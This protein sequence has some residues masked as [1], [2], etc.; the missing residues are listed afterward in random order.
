MVPS[1]QVKKTSI[2]YSV[3]PKHNER[4]FR[5]INGT[6]YLDLHFHKITL[7]TSWR[8]MAIGNCGVREVAFRFQR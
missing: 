5:F 6:G 2:G 3:L 1:D 7:A 8:T 4:S